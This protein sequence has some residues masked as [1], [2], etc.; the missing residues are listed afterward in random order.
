MRMIFMKKKLW[1]VV[2]IVISGL[3]AL[4][5]LLFEKEIQLSRVLQ[6]LGI[7]PI[8]LIPQVLRKL[9]SLKTPKILETVYL[10]FI[11][12]AYFCGIAL[13]WYE[14][15][16]YFDKLVHF[17][18]GFVSAMLGVYILV[19]SKQYSKKTWFNALFIVMMSLSVAGLWEFFEFTCDSIFG[20]DA[21]KVLTTGVTDTMQDMI[22]AFLASL[23][24][25]T[26]YCFETWNKKKGIVIKLIERM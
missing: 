26:T 18:S 15:V 16:P 3:V 8:M 19:Q 7:V 10:I 25:I 22:V 17:L 2:L 12:L 23:L 21:Q 24:F 11:F 1:N 6:L 4:G 9:F 14:S 20:R 5:M 13:G